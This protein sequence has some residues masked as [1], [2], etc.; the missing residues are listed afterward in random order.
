MGG[1]EAR[2]KRRDLEV[3]WSNA[4]TPELDQA[5]DALPQLSDCPHDLY[6]EL[7]KPTRAQKKHALV[8]ENGRPMTLISLRSCAR[9]WEPVA[10]QCVPSAIAPAVSTSALARA[11]HAL[12]MEVRVP[13]GLREEV[14]ELQPSD[15]WPY[16]CHVIDLHGDYEAYWRERK[17][18][19][20]L[21]RAR[22]DTEHLT[23]RV[24]GE[25]DLQWIV[26]T[27]GEE[28]KNDPG[29][30]TLATEDRFA[31]WSALAKRSD[32]PLKLHTLILADGDRR[33]AGLVL[34]SKADVASTQCSVRDPSYNDAGTAMNLL[35]V[36]WAKAQGFRQL[37]L[38]SGV[39]KRDWGPV[40][41]QRYGAVFRPDVMSALSWACSY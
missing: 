27:W 28:W 29:Q 10:Y 22:R 38:G 1:I 15:H 8:L 9:H 25:G 19:K 23:P 39:Y 2:A 5:L 35:V 17:R 37:D 36:E 16:E 32:L 30:E 40:G 4:W 21:R 3:R 11:L 34:L 13:A 41:G 31:L 18:Q 33:A 12:G 6:R 14:T 26:E 20:R 24:N 7:L